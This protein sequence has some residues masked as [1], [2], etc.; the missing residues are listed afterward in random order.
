MTDCFAVLGLPRRPHCDEDALKEI[1]HRRAALLHPDAVTG[2]TDAFREL[3]E[4]YATLADSGRR[5]RHLQ[6]LAFPDFQKVSAAA[7][8]G[9]LFLAVGQAVQAAREI[10][11]R[12][13]R[14]Q[15]A[16]ARALLTGEIA[17]AGDGIRAALRDV[18]AVRERLRAELTALDDRWP[19]V[20]AGEISLLASQLTF[21]SRWQSELA[22]WEFRIKQAAA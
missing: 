17:A 8:Q 12:H 21:L 4:A 11:Q 22:E 16:L 3:Q 1:Y 19:A 15:S 13:E 14:S 2:G 5:L 9:D 10:L 7:P 6:E 20:E 18:A